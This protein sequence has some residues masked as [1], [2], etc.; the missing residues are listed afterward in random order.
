MSEKKY[1]SDVKTYVIRIGRM[2]DAQK[3][4]YTALSP[5]WCVPYEHALLDYEKLFGNKN[6]VVIEIGFGMGAATAIIASQNPDVNYIGIEVHKPGVGKLLGEIAAQNLTNIRIIEHDALEVLSHMIA[7]NSVAAFH[8]F[9]PDPWP[10]KRHHKRRL[11]QRPRTELFASKLALGGYFYMATDWEAYAESA[12][13][14]LCATQNLSNKYDGFASAQAWR[15]RT[16]FEE[17]G[18][19]EDRVIRELYFVKK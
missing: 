8:V 5:V 2:T 12:L 1:A 13:A 11:V 6:P 4:N 19:N 7:N 14:E 15:P 10:K 9:F 16:K 18:I 3:K 17:R